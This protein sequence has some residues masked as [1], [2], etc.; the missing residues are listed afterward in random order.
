[1]RDV[2]LLF[3]RKGRGSRRA[4]VFLISRAPSPCIRHWRCRWF[5]PRSIPASSGAG[6][7]LSSVRGRSFSNSST[8]SHRVGGV[9]RSWPNSNDGSRPPPRHCCVRPKTRPAHYHR[10]ASL[11]Q[12]P[13]VGE[14]KLR[15]NDRA[16]A[17]TSAGGSARRG[18]VTNEQRTDRI[19]G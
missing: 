10:Q 2:Q 14:A 17:G 18:E 11:P 6:E 13:P 4:R 9:E 16:S 19:R 8:R 5:L 12:P 1:M 3:S 7:A 15:I